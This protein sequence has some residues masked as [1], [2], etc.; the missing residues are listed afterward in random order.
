MPSAAYNLGVLYDQGLGV[1]ADAAQALAW[2]RKAADAGHAGA[3]YTLGQMYYEGIGVE[4]ND[5]H[6]AALVHGCG[7][8]RATARRSTTWA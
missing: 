8:A 1:A 4:A 3:Q 7:G 5:A 2:Y 6:G